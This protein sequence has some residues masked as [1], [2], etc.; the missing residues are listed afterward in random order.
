MI[1]IK[2]GRDNLIIPLSMASQSLQWNI[3]DACIFY[4]FVSLTS[5]NGEVCN[6]VKRQGGKMQN[7]VA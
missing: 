6:L 3:D 2:K 4:G 5:N 7:K 1:Y